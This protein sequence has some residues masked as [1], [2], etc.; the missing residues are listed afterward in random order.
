MRDQLDTNE[1]EINFNDI[2]NAIKDNLIFFLLFNLLVVILSIVITLS[3]PN[4]YTSR[5][6]LEVMQ[7]SSGGNSSMGGNGFAQQITGISIGGA[8]NSSDPAHAII[9]IINSRD[10][11]NHLLS[12]DNNLASI[13]AWK[14]YDQES[15]K[16]IFKSNMYDDQTNK[17]LIPTPSYLEGYRALHWDL[18]VIRSENS[19]FIHLSY[20]H[21][22]PPY[23][24][25][26]VDLIIKEINQLLRLQDLTETN[27][28][29]EYLYQQ[30]RETKESEIKLSINQIIES[31]LRKKMLANIREN[32]A[33][34]PI[35]PP[36]TPDLKS[37][38]VRSFIVIV[39]SIIGFIV[40]LVILLTLRFGFRKRFL[41]KKG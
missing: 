26:L 14:D 12:I 27:N 16:I 7:K 11:A 37:S 32:Y 17:W 20:E 34:Q 18:N 2:Y 21:V 28:S 33:I 24:K 3:M 4:K 19:G 31:Q 40:S 39:S 8:V 23:S 36:F 5:T 25:Y 29:L 35:D 22:S 10:F 41:F 38:P 30:L 1:N 15:K 9:A 6:V 13:L